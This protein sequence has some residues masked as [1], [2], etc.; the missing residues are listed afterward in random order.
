ML[1]AQIRSLH[2]PGTIKDVSRHSISL[3]QRLVRTP[4]F[5]PR[6]LRTNQDTHRAQH[7]I[8][9]ASQ[10]VATTDDH[11]QAAGS[12]NWNLDGPEA[13]IEVTPKA[14]LVVVVPFEGNSPLGVPWQ[15]VMLQMARKLVWVD[16][17]FQLKVHTAAALPF[18]PFSSECI[19]AG[20]FFASLL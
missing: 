17:G 19:R 9:G 15:V 2:A 16:P 14:K 11:S 3:D 5:C 1:H 18:F 4:P 12:V 20:N 6:R 10:T 7:V 13:D 8:G